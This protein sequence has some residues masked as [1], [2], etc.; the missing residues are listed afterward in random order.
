MFGLGCW[1]VFVLVV[2][3]LFV[4]N[5][6]LMFLFIVFVMFV[7]MLLL[8]VRIFVLGKLVRLCVFVILVSWW[9]VRL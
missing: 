9:C 7:W 1:L 2:V 4:M 3:R 8:I 6:V 5:R